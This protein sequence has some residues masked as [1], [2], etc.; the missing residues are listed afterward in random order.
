MNSASPPHTIQI[1]T[2]FHK[3]SSLLWTLVRFRARAVT[4][5]Y[6]KNVP[7]RQY[8]IDIVR[9]ALFENTLVCLPTGLGKTLIAA[10]VMYN[11]YNWFPKVCDLSNHDLFADLIE[12]KNCLLGTNE[13]SCRSATRSMSLPSLHETGS[14]LSDES[15]H[16]TGACH[17]IKPVG[18]SR[19]DR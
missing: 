12:G 14:P 10:V 1:D 17:F 3:L 11:F 15:I 6:P 13:A 4:W 19:D 16:L 9:T 8:Q 2:S 5:F 18:H 7:A